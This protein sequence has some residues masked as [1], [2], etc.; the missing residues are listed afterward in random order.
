TIARDIPIALGQIEQSIASA[1]SQAQ[2]SRPRLET[3]VAQT[4][5]AAA[6]AIERLRSA[7]ATLRLSARD[8]RVSEQ[9]SSVP[10]LPLAELMTVRSQRWLTWCLPLAFAAIVLP[11]TLLQHPVTP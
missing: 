2:T 7:V 1:I 9:L 6:A 11:L 4:R 5:A 10:T 3:T 8:D